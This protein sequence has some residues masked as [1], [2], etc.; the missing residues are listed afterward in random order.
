[1]DKLPAEVLYNI[2]DHIPKSWGRYA[3]INCLRTC[4]L[5]YNVGLPLLY[6]R[7]TVES[8][9]PHRFLHQFPS[10]K[11]EMVN[12]V[13]LSITASPADRP[14]VG[15][16]ICVVESRLRELAALLP[17]MINLSTFSFNFQDF[18]PNHPRPIRIHRSIICKLVENLP[19]S[20][21]N[22]EI[23][24]N[25]LDDMG[26]NPLH[27]CDRLRD[28]LPRLQHLRLRMAEICP[29]IFATGFNQDG[30]TAQQSTITR[31][32]APFLKTVMINCCAY[33]G[34][35]RA[36][37]TQDGMD[38]HIPLLQRLHEFAACG[39]FPAIERL[40]L[41]HKPRLGDVGS[42][43]RYYKRCDIMQNQTWCI[44]LIHGYCSN[45]DTGR[46]CFSRTPEGQ[47]VFSF[48][49]STLEQLVEEQTWKITPGS[50]RVPSADIEGLDIRRGSAMGSRDLAD[51]RAIER[52]DCQYHR[53]WRKE[54]DA[55]VQFLRPVLS[56]GLLDESPMT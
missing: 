5:C 45:G 42:Q 22:L 14:N 26:T 24:A 41:V 38:A 51:H 9:W 34:P 8:F 16:T 23:D 30:T 12:F 54:C 39:S 49:V 21:V 40:W 13:T 6:D 19:T 7:I 17:R 44:P 36:C 15:G 28:V 33:Q 4:R 55:G 46:S 37:G 47:E 29:G 32:V 53:L 10:E 3:L 2:L 25:G 43:Y 1:M 48:G 52:C 27:L 35:A 20:C 31:V 50:G 56:E 18:E 11:L